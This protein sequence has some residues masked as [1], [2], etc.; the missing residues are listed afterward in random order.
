MDPFKRFKLWKFHGTRTE[1]YSDAVFAIVITLLVLEIKVP[2]LQDAESPDELLSALKEMLPKI[3]SWAVS[4]FF[5]SVL[6]VQHHNVFRMAK[7]IDYGM[8]WINNIFLFSIAFIPFPTALM[9][10]YPHN[11]PGV[12]LFGV[13]AT[14]ASLMQVWL[15]HCVANSHLL[16]IYNREKVMRNV[17]RSFIL[18][19]CLLIAAVG[20]S[21]VS[22]WLPYVIYAVVPLF[23]LL[24]FDEE[25]EVPPT[26]L[27]P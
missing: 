7:N 13:N 23:F 17:L 21:F 6:W 1:A 22:L 9:G 18:A 24:P 4:F 2:H 5:V 19:P 14:V 26:P 27:A 16:P 25:G 3:I 11:Q 8:V 10:E 20:G 12:L 15:Y